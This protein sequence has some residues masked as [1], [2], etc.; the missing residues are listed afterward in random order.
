MIMR[1]R[2]YIVTGV[3]II[4]ITDYLINRWT[5]ISLLEYK[6]ISGLLIEFIIIDFIPLL[7]I[8]Y[9]VS[10]LITNVSKINVK[11]MYISLYF[12]MTF[13]WLLI[14]HSIPKEY[15]YKENQLNM[16]NHYGL[17]TAIAVFAVYNFIKE[18]YYGE[19]EYSRYK[20]FFSFTKKTAS[21]IT[22]IVSCNI[23]M[24]YYVIINLIVKYTELKW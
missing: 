22:S 3:I 13:I 1:C 21:V 23:I 19:E 5:G 10:I 17:N 14:L 11:D 16:Y 9:F 7:I 2:Q 8:C 20:T 18:K 6:S 4:L 24:I 12:I 15:M